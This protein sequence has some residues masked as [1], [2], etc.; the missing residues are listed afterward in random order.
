MREIWLMQPRFD[1][2]SGSSPNALV[3]QPR[4]RAGYDFLRLRADAGEVDAAL[5][6][7]WED[8]S[9]GSDDER[10]ALLQAAKEAASP[11][12][13]VVA[14]RPEDAPPRKRRRRR[15]KTSAADESAPGD[16]QIAESEATPAADAD[17]DAQRTETR[18]ARRR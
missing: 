7:W 10:I 11:R 3:E 18:P 16:A 14:L 1:R 12:G 13:E 17:A 15:R 2:R 6:E 4:F 9:L 5:A 8:F